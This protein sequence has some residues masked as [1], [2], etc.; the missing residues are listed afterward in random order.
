M[1][2]PLT[3]SRPESHVMET[4]SP[5]LLV[6]MVFGSRPRSALIR[7][8]VLVAV[9]V[10][11]FKFLLVPIRVSGTSMEPTFHNGGINLVYRYS[12]HKA[13]PA[14][15]DVVAIRKAGMQELYFKR[16]IGLPGE[17]LII[18]RGVV[19]INGEPLDEPYV[20]FRESWND[21]PFE[22]DDDEFFVIGDNRGME[23]SNHVYG[24]VRR[25][26]IIGKP[27]F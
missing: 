17:Q 3:Y 13:D 27:L 7:A 2:Q 18:S 6:R 9:C 26:A 14:R 4:S 10:V 19:V 12:F 5:P 8:A 25:E 1:S 24:R 11:V 15:G 21:G 22:L 16:V 20:V 23:Q